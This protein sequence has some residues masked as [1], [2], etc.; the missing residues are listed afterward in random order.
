MLSNNTE[1]A[2]ISAKKRKLL[3]TRKRK[4]RAA[5]P[6]PP[7][8]L[9]RLGRMTLCSE[10]LEEKKKRKERT[11]RARRTEVGR[12]SRAEDGAFEVEEELTTETRAACPVWVWRERRQAGL[13]GHPDVQ[14]QTHI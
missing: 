10:S 8:L 2:T 7:T 3:E 4:K 11:D 5:K 12:M 13:S 6:G 9:E 14:R 1:R